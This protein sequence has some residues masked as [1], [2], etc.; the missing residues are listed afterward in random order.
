V[1]KLKC[2]ECN[3]TEDVQ[4]STVHWSAG[5]RNCGDF[6]WYK[7]IETINLCEDCEDTWEICETCGAL[8][9]GDYMWSGYPQDRIG[10]SYVCPECALK[11]G[12]ELQ[13]NVYD[14]NRNFMNHL[15]YSPGEPRK[16]KEEIS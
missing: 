7:N 6:N 14:E 1:S 3:S 12:I 5:G 2:D 10:H 15:A 4:P 11:E 9:D 8:I 13:V 16:L